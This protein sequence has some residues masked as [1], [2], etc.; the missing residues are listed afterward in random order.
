MDSRCAPRFLFLCLMC[1]QLPFLLSHLL[2]VLTHR[3]SP[4]SAPIQT[5][6]NSLLPLLRG[7]IVYPGACVWCLLLHALRPVHLVQ[8]GTGWKLR[9]SHLW[10]LFSV[11]FSGHSTMWRIYSLSESERFPYRLCTVLAVDSMR[12][13]GP[14]I[15]AL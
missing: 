7:Y 12:G 2:F 9:R 6:P 5:Q 10:L 11:L 1:F 14:C 4:S 13:W 8:S 15:S 3:F